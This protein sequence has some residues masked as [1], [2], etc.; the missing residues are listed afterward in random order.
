VSLG[1]R[2]SS[3]KTAPVQSEP[4]QNGW[5]REQVADIQRARVLSAMVEVCAE[6]G[7]AAV[8]VADVVARAGVSRR[9]F[10]ELFADREECFLA[11]FD[12]AIERALGYVLESYD[13][14][15]RWETRI[16]VA[17]EGLLCFLDR[18]RGMARLLVV[19][20]LAAG[21]AALERRESVL[22]R[23]IMLLEEGRT[24]TGGGAG[25]GSLTAEGVLGGVLSVVHARIVKDERCPLIELAGPLMGMTVLPYRGA[26]AARKEVERPVPERVLDGG[27][28][29]GDPLRGLGMRL[30]Y[31]TVCVLMSVAAGPGSSNREIGDAAG[32]SDQG[33]ISKLLSRLEHLGLV[34]NTCPVPGTGAPN[35]WVLTERGTAIHTT[36]AT[37]T[38]P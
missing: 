9:T 4:A 11:A 19:E 23:M 10:Y 26:A 20:S 22:A 16:R 13:P 12:D 7:A 2:A 28:S 6:G 8:T 31:R 24:G 36:I 30:T 37:T 27:S 29:G 1:E 35:A 15:A 33:Q 25:L 14:S 3:M 18:E 17:L 32:I 38:S 21:T 5:A 34:R